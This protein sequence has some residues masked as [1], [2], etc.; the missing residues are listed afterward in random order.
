MKKIDFKE[1][2]IVLATIISLVVLWSLMLYVNKSNDPILYGIMAIYTL[3]SFSR[4][5]IFFQNKKKI[6]QMNL[7][8]QKILNQTHLSKHMKLFMKKVKKY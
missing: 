1:I 5:V 2:I 3:I 4:I 8:Y 7:F 6:S